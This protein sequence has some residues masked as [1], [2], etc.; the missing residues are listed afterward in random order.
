[1]EFSP[2]YF[3]LYPNTKDLSLSSREYIERSTWDGLKRIR[4]LIIS[5]S[6]QHDR[7]SFLQLSKRYDYLIIC[8][9]KLLARAERNFLK[10]SLI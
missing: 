4:K 10:V 8:G 2:Y 7:G 1:M 6:M 3:G 9:L 5:Y